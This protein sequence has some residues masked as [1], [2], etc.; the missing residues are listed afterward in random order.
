MKHIGLLLMF[1][2]VAMIGGTCV[3]RLHERVRLLKA[4]RSQ[5][6]SVKRRL[7]VGRPS[8]YELFDKCDDAFIYPFFDIISQQMKKG[9]PPDE[10]V[11]KAFNC[12]DG[13]RLLKRDER[14]VLSGCFASISISDIATALRILDNA[15]KELDTYIEQATDEERKNAKPV[16]SVAVYIGLAAVILLW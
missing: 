14:E 4:F 2:A 9:K 8:F 5:I 11:K 13:A 3:S 12:A 1:S 10:A 16:M 6:L 7:S 15:C